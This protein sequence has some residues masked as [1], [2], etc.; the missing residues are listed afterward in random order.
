MSSQHT[1]A[2]D[3]AIRTFLRHAVATLAY[4]GRK[5][6]ADTPPDVAGFRAGETA[7]TPKEILAHICDLLDW[8]AR[9]ARGWQKWAVRSCETWDEEVE[10]FFTALSALDSALAA[11]EPLGFPAEKIFQGPIADGLAH[12]GQI[13]ILRRIAGANIRSENYFK[14]EIAAGRVGPDQVAPSLEFD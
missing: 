9:L 4:R 6:V 7:R 11:D 5:V 10:R 12:I 3:Q 8:A 14:A 13:A 2:G 1:D